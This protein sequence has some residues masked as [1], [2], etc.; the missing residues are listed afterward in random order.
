MKKLNF[1][2]F[3]FFHRG[4]TGSLAIIVQALGFTAPYTFAEYLSPFKVKDFLFWE[5]VFT[6]KKPPC[7]NPH[8]TPKGF[9]HGGKSI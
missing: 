9:F 2:C 1:Y 5:S 3:P 8:K 6:G 7:V 4:H